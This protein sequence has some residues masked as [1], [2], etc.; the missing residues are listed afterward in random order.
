MCFFR[1]GK[2]H[3]N[4]VRTSLDVMWPIIC[5]HIVH[6]RKTA[7]I[8]NNCCI[9]TEGTTKGNIY[10]LQYT[11]RCVGWL[12]GCHNV[13][14]WNNPLYVANKDLKN[15]IALLQTVVNDQLIFVVGD[16]ILVYILCCSYVSN[17]T[18]FA[19]YFCETTAI[20]ALFGLFY[21]SKCMFIPYPRLYI[22]CLWFNM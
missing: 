16:A 12:A 14:S 10:V 22:R 9:D 6:T 7:H 20:P 15:I 1:F 2:L 17:L 19:S 3:V 4:L 5:T 13:C 21:T 18:K 11:K 8:T